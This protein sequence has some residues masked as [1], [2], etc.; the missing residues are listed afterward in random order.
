MVIEMQDFTKEVKIGRL[1]DNHRYNVFVNI[2]YNN[3]RLSITGE[4]S[5]ISKRCMRSAG[6][7]TLNPDEIEYASGWNKKKVE[8]LNEIWNNWHLNDLRAGCKHQ[9]TYWD[10]NKKVEVFNF[11]WSKKFH[12]MRKRAEDGLMDK[13]EYNE[14]KQI[15][16]S[17]FEATVNTTHHKWL[18]PL[19]CGLLYQGLIQ[20]KGKETT[21]AHWVR[22][23]EHPE[24]LLCKPCK[25]CGYKYGTK[26]LHEDVPEEILKELMEM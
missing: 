1:K 3:K 8:R 17:V 9:R 21:D 13:K 12:N 14:Y 23:E 22:T 24:G 26:W 15:V 20:I 16:L 5:T 25:I 6:Q 11:T 2:E 19:V 10:L 18:S 7:I 4:E